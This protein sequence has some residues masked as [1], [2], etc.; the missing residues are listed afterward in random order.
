LIE[1]YSFR[2]IV[3]FLSNSDG[4]VIFVCSGAE[5]FQMIRQLRVEP[6]L[7]KMSSSGLR[8]DNTGVNHLF[9]DGFCTNKFSF[10]RSM[11]VDERRKSSI[12]CFDKNRQIGKL[13]RVMSR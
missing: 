4:R 3:D 7:F 2:G 8:V 13:I 1:F 12:A 11:L 10:E 6:Y 5:K 9:V